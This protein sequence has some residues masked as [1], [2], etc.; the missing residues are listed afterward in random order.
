VWVEIEGIGA[1]AALIPSRPSRGVWVEIKMSREILK[2]I[3]S[4]PSRGVWVEIRERVAHANI[5]AVAPL[6]GRVG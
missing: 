2:L 4:R 3:L 6:A 5:G 1:E